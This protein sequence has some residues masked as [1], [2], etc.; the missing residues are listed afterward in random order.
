[1]EIA[2]DLE[3]RADNL[4]KGTRKSAAARVQRRFSNGSGNRP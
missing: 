4:E 2:Q 1:L 3:T